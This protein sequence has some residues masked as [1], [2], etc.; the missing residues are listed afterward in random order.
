MAC[1]SQLYLWPVF[2]NIGSLFNVFANPSASS[3]DGSKFA[4]LHHLLVKQA[5]LLDFDTCTGQFSNKRLIAFTDT[6][7]NFIEIK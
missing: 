6:N 5:V 4:I 7:V 3:P 1:N 2:Q